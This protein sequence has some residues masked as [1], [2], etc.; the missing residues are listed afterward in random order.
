MLD[1]MTLQ[2]DLRH[3]GYTQ[4]WTG[5]EKRHAS[6]MKLAANLSQNQFVQILMV[7]IITG[8]HLMKKIYFGL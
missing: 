8:I 7:I 1:L 2:P 4:K 5:K 3:E 6:G